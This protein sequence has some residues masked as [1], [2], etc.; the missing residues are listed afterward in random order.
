MHF[1][2][3]AKDMDRIQ[4][5]YQET[6]GWDFINQGPDY[7]NYRVIETGK[8][9]IGINGG[10]TPREGDPPRGG[11]P[12]SSYVCVIGVENIDETI[13]K[14]EK[15][16]GSVVMEKMDVPKVGLLAYYKDPE[17]NLFGV[18]QPTSGQLVA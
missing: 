13:A 16:G 10:L 6:F 15:A 4:R 9:P 2:I 8:D 11:E 5:F 1:E 18:I 14:I 12:I 3:H 17:G 7:A